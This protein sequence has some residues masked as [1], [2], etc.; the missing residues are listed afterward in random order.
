M[1]HQKIANIKK[2]I[3]LITVY[4]SI[5]LYTPCPNKNVHLLFYEELSQK[6]VAILV[7]L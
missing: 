7:K 2:V 5:S 1:C 3:L 4:R 6:S